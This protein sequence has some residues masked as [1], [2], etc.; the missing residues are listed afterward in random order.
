MAHIGQF[1]Q[2]DT[3]Q[4]GNLPLFGGEGVKDNQIIF[5]QILTDLTAPITI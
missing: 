5:V 3:T 4:L 2:H 1:K